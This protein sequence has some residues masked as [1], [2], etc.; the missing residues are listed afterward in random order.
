[1]DASAGHPGQGAAS[2]IKSIGIVGIGDVKQALDRFLA[3]QVHGRR[4]DFILCRVFPGHRSKTFGEGN[5][6]EFDMG[7]HLLNI[8]AGAISDII[9]DV[10]AASTQ[11]TVVFIMCLD[12]PVRKP[13]FTGKP[14]LVLVGIFEQIHGQ[15]HG[16][17]ICLGFDN[18]NFPIVTDFIGV[19]EPEGVLPIF[20]SYEKIA[21]STA[22]KLNEK[23]FT[24]SRFSHQ[25][26]CHFGGGSAFGGILDV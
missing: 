20:G 11:G 5:R 16:I 13:E 22:E 7:E 2:Q 23:C 15:Y 1:M 8:P 17:F 26:V 9:P 19:D 21:V 6:H 10:Y 4:G 24:V 12:I 25:D 14:F 3:Q 18:G